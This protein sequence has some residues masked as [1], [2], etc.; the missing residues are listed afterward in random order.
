[1]TPQDAVSAPR[2][3]CHGG[4][5]ACHSRIPGAVVDAVARRH[6]IV[7][8]GW[9]HGGFALVHAIG[10]GPDGRLDGGADTGAHG[11]ALAVDQPASSSRQSR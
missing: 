9:G 3:D 1:M 8:T 10:I 6:P 5:I 11:M 2:F 4:P 7:R